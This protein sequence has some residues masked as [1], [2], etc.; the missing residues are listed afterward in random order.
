MGEQMRKMWDK[1]VVVLL[2][3]V[4]VIAAVSLG[5]SIGAIKG[6]DQ[7]VITQESQRK[8]RAAM[9][10]NHRAEKKYLRDQ[11]AERNATIARQSDQLAALAAKAS[12]GNKAAIQII[13]KQ[14][15]KAV[16]K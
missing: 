11:L 12:E 13:D 3:V 7:T 1:N 5:M 4:S 16:S 9:T 8:E 10:R 15:P 14:T 2:M 6:Q